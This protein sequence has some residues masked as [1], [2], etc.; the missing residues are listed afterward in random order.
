MPHSSK[1]NIIIVGY[2]KSGTTWLSKLIAELAECPLQGDWGF[3]HLEQPYM[4]G[5]ARSSEFQC[6]KSHHTYSEIGNVSKAPIHKIVYLVRDP[7]DVVISGMHFFS[8]SHFKKPFFN[9]F[10]FSLLSR[11]SK[12]IISRKEKKRQMIHAV[13]HGAP[14]INQ[15]LKTSW[16]DHY[17]GYQ[18]TEALC[19]KYEDLLISPV[20]EAKKIMSYLAIDTTEKHI[21]NCVRAQSFKKQK[22]KANTYN[23]EALKKIIRKGSSGYWKNEFTEKEISLFKDKIVMDQYNF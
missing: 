2:P 15:W 11:I 9:R 13:L 21:E 6:F 18:N 3:E 5:L 19:I 4:E 7:R 22:E 14:F 23:N 8:F 1:K 12:K 17:R 16:E 20:K 10:F